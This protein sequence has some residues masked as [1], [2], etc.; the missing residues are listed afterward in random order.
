MLGTHIIVSWQKNQ[1][2]WIRKIIKTN[3]ERNINNNQR[4]HKLGNERQREDEEEEEKKNTT[5]MKSNKR[6]K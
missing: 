6:G 2:K 5:Q 4:E 3:A 1:D